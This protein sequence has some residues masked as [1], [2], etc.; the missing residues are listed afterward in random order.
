MVY[1][2]LKSSIVL[3]SFPAI[4]ASVYVLDK[5]ILD[6][7]RYSDWKTGMHHHGPKKLSKCWLQIEKIL[8]LWILVD[9]SAL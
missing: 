3:F 4:C 2:P 8:L 6:P 7:C 5:I 1:H 9:I